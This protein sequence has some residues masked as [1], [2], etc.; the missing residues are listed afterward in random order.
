MKRYFFGSL[1]MLVMLGILGRFTPVQAKVTVAVEGTSNGELLYAWKG[2][3]G[4][5]TLIKASKSAGSIA[6]AKAR[7]VFHRFKVIIGNAVVS[8][9]TT[10]DEDYTHVRAGSLFFGKAKFIG[11]RKG[12]VVKNFKILYHING[13]LRCYTPEQDLGEGYA[14]AQVETQVRFNG[15]NRFAGTATVDG[16]SGYDGGTGDLAGAFTGDT[17]DVT[18]DNDFTM[19]LGRVR[20]GRV[21]SMLFMGAT[22]VSYGAEVPIDYC[23]ADFYNS[24]DMSVAEETKQTKGYFKFTAAKPV[25]ISADPQPFSFTNLPDVTIY[26]EDNNEDFLDE[27]DANT[28]QLFERIGDTGSIQPW[29]GIL[30]TGD[31]DSDGTPDRGLVFKGYDADHTSLWDVLLNSYYGYKDNVYLYLIGETNNGVPFSGKLLFETE[32]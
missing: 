1:T 22:L 25:A 14:M 5:D 3:S 18:V 2:P 9:G 4:L 6:S 32:A 16:V 24:S 10:G 13:R 20:D 31:F 29:G 19:P 23:S 8:A 28:V 12:Q 7:A 26:V 27:I 17:Y 15:K 11:A 21:Y 30:D